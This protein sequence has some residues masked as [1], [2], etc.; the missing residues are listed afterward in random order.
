MKKS[1]IAIAL[2][3]S[4]ISSL[5]SCVVRDGRRG[6]YRHDRGYR[7]DHHYNNGYNR[8]Y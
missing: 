4:F 8:G 1:I 3:V 6:P 2:V 7:G 5:S